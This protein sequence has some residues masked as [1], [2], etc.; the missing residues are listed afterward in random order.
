MVMSL[1]GTQKKGKS[2]QNAPRTLLE[3]E[4]SKLEVQGHKRSSVLCL[5]KRK[6][7][8]K[9]FLRRGTTKGQD[10]RTHFFWE[11]VLKG[12]VCDPP[13]RALTF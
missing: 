10:S 7:K 2:S 1:A 5:E 11:E 13:S 8:K 4:T 12:L 9:G 3:L 6:K